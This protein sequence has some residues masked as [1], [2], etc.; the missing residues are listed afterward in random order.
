M[1]RRWSRKCLPLWRRE[2]NCRGREGG[3]LSTS[4]SLVLFECFSLC[5][6]CLFKTNQFF[7]KRNCDSQRFC[8]SL[9]FIMCVYVHEFLWSQPLRKALSTP[10]WRVILQTWNNSPSSQSGVGSAEAQSCCS[11]S[12]IIITEGQR[13]GQG[14]PVCW[15]VLALRVPPVMK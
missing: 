11:G 1:P 2:L 5:M 13:P 3:L 9:H 15:A 14:R 10:S 8:S 4:F 7:K 6:Y 12:F